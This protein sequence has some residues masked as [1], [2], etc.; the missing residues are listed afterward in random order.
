ME[1]RWRRTRRRR[2]PELLVEAAAR[3]RAHRAHRRLDA[4]ARLR[5]GRARAAPT[6][7]APRCGSATSAACR[8]TTGCS[9]FGMADDA[10]LGRLA[11]G[12]RPPVMRME[13][14]LGPEAGAASYE[15]LVRERA[16]RRA[17]LGPAAARARAGRALRVAVPRQA[18]GRGALAAGRGR[19][20]RRHGAAGAAH[21]ADAAGARTRAP[22]RVPGHRR[23]TRR[24]RSRA[25][26]ATRP[27]PA[28]PRRTCARGAGELLVLLD[29]AAARSSR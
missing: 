15:A 5:A 1:I 27:T 24:R 3:G 8:P 26:S 17:A 7:A 6:G 29:A 12:Q 13:G 28:R 4:Q 11:D 10:L 20:A 25:R 14:E 9:N 23:A 16:R 19:R 2:S 22:G 18:G 21:L